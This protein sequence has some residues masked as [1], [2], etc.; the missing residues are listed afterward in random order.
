MSES[1]QIEASNENQDD[2]NE[3]PDKP[4]KIIHTFFH[5]LLF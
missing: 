2:V 5:L 4:K 1:T 3:S